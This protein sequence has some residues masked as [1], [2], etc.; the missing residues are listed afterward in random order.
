MC[1]LS[2]KFIKEVCKSGVVDQIVN[3]AKAKE[4]VDIQRKMK[5]FF[6]FCVKSREAVLPIMCGSA[7]SSLAIIQNLSDFIIW[8]LAKFRSPTHSP[9]VQPVKCLAFWVCR[10]WKMRTKPVARTRNVVP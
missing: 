1:K 4:K 7:G 6:F 2:D 10:N 8:I 3:W 9:Q 5:G